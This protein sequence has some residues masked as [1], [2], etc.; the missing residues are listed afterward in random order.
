HQAAAHGA[1]AI[2]LIAAVLGEREM[3]DFRELAEKYR[4]SALVEVHDAE[5]LKPALASGARIVGV[6]NRNLHTFEVDLDVSM[7]LAEQ[8]PSE[9]V[10]VAESGI[11]SSADVR[12]LAAAGYQGFLV[13]EHLMKS[14]DP[15]GSLRALLS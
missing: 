5:E 14:G 10:R 7:R 13:G 9:I 15:A 6:N 12:K 11:H 8:I 3:R 2:L 4:M 1:D